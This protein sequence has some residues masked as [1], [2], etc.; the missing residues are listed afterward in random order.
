[1]LTKSAYHVVSL[2]F[3]VMLQQSQ[4]DDVPLI[5]DH[6]LTYDNN[7]NSN[8]SNN[9]S[10]NNN[11]NNNSNNNNS[12]N[13]NNNDERLHQLASTQVFVLSVAVIVCGGIAIVCNNIALIIYS[14]L[15]LDLSAG[16]YCGAFVRVDLICLFTRFV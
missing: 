7:T 3:D 5:T 9:N 15:L 16:F 8:N 10:N 11:N 13:N 2:Q 12:N 1:M 6:H 14:G 4:E